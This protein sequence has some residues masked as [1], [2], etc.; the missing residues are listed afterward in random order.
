MPGAYQWTA[1]SQRR[2]ALG[3][4]SDGVRVEVRRATASP[5]EHAPTEEASARRASWRAL[6]RAAS[7]PRLRWRASSMGEVMA[8]GR[9]AANRI[10]VLWP[11]VAGGGWGWAAMPSATAGTSSSSY[12]ARAREEL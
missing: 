12:L 9:R 11:A 4:S 7:A 10:A 3:H 1:P 6:P 8:E 2:R 5:R